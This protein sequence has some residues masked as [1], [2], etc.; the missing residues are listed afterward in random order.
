[1][2]ISQTFW[3]KAQEYAVNEYGSLNAYGEYLSKKHGVK[4][5]LSSYR[6]VGRLM[7]YKFIE[8][9]EKFMTDDEMFLYANE[10]VN[11]SNIS[12]EGEDFISDYV[13][14]LN[15]SDEMKE[16]TRI[17]RKEQRRKMIEA[18]NKEHGE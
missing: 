18:I 14:N 12:E 6:R 16:Y 15:I 17:K 2:N 5:N 1:M 7:S 4:V 10:L 3:K 9:V 11:A 8:D 13:T